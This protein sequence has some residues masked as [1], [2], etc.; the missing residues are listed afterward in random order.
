M[1][2]EITAS[3]HGLGDRTERGFVFAPIKHERAHLGGLL[4][5]QTSILAGLS[6]GREP[7][8]VKRGAWLA[9]KIVAVT[10]GRSTAQC[11]GH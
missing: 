11:A 7:N 4:S 3:Y 8:A 2:N 10:P 6:D 1:A 9:R 5:L